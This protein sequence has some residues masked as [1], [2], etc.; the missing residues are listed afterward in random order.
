M[1]RE[2]VLQE[3]LKLPHRERAEVAVEVFA[4]LEEEPAE[5]P[6]EVEKAWGAEI[7]RRARRVVA[8]ESEGTPWEEVKQRIERRLAK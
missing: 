3:A 5:D 8:G 6:M 7:E 1:T 4:S 2:A